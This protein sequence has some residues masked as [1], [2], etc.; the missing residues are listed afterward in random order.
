MRRFR[1]SPSARVQYVLGSSFYMPPEAHAALTRSLDLYFGALERAPPDLD[2][3]PDAGRLDVLS[4]CAYAFQSLGELQDTFPSDDAALLEAWAAH[5]ERVG[6]TRTGSVPSALF[7]AS[8]RLFE[9]TADGQHAVLASQSRAAPSFPTHA[10]DDEM[11][12]SSLVAPASLLETWSDQ[13]SCTTAM[14]GQA[15]DAAALET[16]LQYAQAVVARAQAYVASLPDGF[17][18]AQS[19][20]GEW[21]DELAAL[22]WNELAVRAAAAQRAA[23][24]ARAA[25]EAWPVHDADVAMVAQL[26]AEVNGHAA[27]LLA[28][29]PPPQSLTSVRGGGEAQHKYERGVQRLCDVADYAQS[30][31]TIRIHQAA[32]DAADAAWAL[33]GLATRCL[34]TAAAAL[35]PAGK[36]ASSASVT[37]AAS[38]AVPG[39]PFEWI[40]MDRGT[41]PVAGATNDS[42]S[43]SRTRASVY[44]SLAQVALT[45]CDA[46]LLAHSA[47]AADAHGRMLMN[48]RIYIRRALVD[49]GLA[50]VHH[51]RTKPNA[52]GALYGRALGHRPPD[53]WEGLAQDA[54]LLMTYV[55]SLFLLGVYES[56]HSPDAHAKTLVELECLGGGVWSLLHTAPS[57]WPAALDPAASVQ[58]LRAALG[59]PTEM[60]AER[61]FWSEVWLPTQ[62]Q[63]AGYPG[64][65]GGLV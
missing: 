23:E 45:R 9:M 34:N 17:G 32:P 31:A 55:R 42:T 62:A 37:S 49:H 29:A 10:T 52:P 20:E 30:L 60:H 54:E 19:P 16:A 13:L 15:S 27:Q 6:G 63:S 28:D 65:P 61:R 53:G 43:V 50:W 24:L 5:V 2:G 40:A 26:E 8:M 44:A 41:A 57:A 1:C 14:L 12:T 25:H 33:T 7:S 4:N 64:L 58:R 47:L 38:L 18:A 22:P 35:E 21:D 59:E 36:G 11:Y 39:A 48:A 51:I 46:S 56:A 3:V